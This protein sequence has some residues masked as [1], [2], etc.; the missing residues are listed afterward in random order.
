MADTVLF[1]NRSKQN[2]T[3]EKQIQELETDSQHCV[4]EYLKGFQKVFRLHRC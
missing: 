2:A 3:R 4:E 1:E